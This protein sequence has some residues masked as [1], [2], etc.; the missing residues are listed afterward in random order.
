MLWPKT[1]IL[2]IPDASKSI[3]TLN[4]H[5]TR[6]TNTFTAGPPEGQG[7][8]NF[9]LDLNKSIKYHGATPREQIAI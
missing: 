7:W 8:I 3:D 4:I 9:I 6:A 2:Y 5:S 1:E